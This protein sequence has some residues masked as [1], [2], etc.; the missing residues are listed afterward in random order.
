MPIPKMQD[1]FKTTLS[2]SLAATDGV[3]YLTDDVVEDIGFLVLERGTN[4]VEIVKY[5]S[6]GSGFVSGTTRGLS[7]VGTSETAGTG[8]AH[9]VGVNVE[10]TTTHF[11]WARAID[12]IN[13]V[14]STSANNFDIGAGAASLSS[15][16]NSYFRIQTSA[17][18]QFQ[19][20]LSTN[21]FAVWTDD[22]GVSYNRLSATGGAI[23]SGTAWENAGGTGN[24]KVSALISASGG[25]SSVSD[26]LVVNQAA[27][28][29]WS[30]AN[31]DV[32]ATNSKIKGTIVSAEAS[33]I[34]RL[35]RGVSAY[36]TDT[37]YNLSLLTD[38]GNISGGGL[39]R[40]AAFANDTFVDDT[41][42][43]AGEVKN[44][45]VSTLSRTPN[46]IWLQGTLSATGATANERQ[47][48]C[49]WLLSGSS[50][51]AGG[52]KLRDT[53]HGF[54]GGAFSVTGSGAWTNSFAL[55]LVEVSAN[56]FTVR[57]SGTDTGGA[58]G[59]SQMINFRWMSESH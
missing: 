48:F 59:N 7:A 52:F 11:Y 17:G 54:V 30:G 55:T 36:S 16:G 15:Q 23:N 9:S 49:L 50:N 31:F 44:L 37:A 8:K 42:L 2:R 41:S 4:N 19:I 26:R 5:G 14:S 33:E 38:G 28:F 22:Q 46:R 53:A 40:N 47:D 6:K 35:V 12:A 21:G 10:M 32:S 56:G 57:L 1:F 27:D 51:P 29:V 18:K 13:G 20:G 39:H 25:I 45:V 43:S 34:N 24:V 58:D 3:I